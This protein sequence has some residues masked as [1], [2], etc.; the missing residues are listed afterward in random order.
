MSEKKTEYKTKT[1]RPEEIKVTA[2]KPTIEELKE[3]RAAWLK[4]A[5]D[6]G[7]IDDLFLIVKAFGVIPE[8]RVFPGRAPL[9]RFEFTDG[10]S[11]YVILF[12]GC[13]W[14]VGAM[15][16]RRPGDT[17]DEWEQV[18]V[19]EGGVEM[20]EVVYGKRL[21]QYYRHL[22]L[23]PHGFMPGNYE[24]QIGLNLYI[25]GYWEGLIGVFAKDAKYQIGDGAKKRTETERN[26][27]LRDLN[28][29]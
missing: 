29:D 9:R 2:K 18:F 20:K 28:L 16:G 27:L 24:E 17:L 7:T 6:N 21:V 10:D 15:R 23:A 5:E 25:P 19:V 8:K 14:G 4:E 12:K 3:Y 13:T 22:N 26:D 11:D 1:P